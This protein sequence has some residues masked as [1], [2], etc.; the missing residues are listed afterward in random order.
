MDDKLNITDG[1]EL[2]DVGKNDDFIPKDDVNKNEENNSQSDP[3]NP[4]QNQEKNVS[5]NISNFGYIIELFKTWFSKRPL[6]AFR[7]IL[8]LK[9]SLILFAIHLIV[10]SITILLSS[11]SFLSIISK[12]SYGFF[13]LSAMTGKLFIPIFFSVIIYYALLNLTIMIIAKIIKTKN[14]SYVNSMSVVSISLIPI[15]I[16]NL[17]S[18]IIGLISPFLGMMVSL[19]SFIIFPITL[20]LGIQINLGKPQKS[21]YWIFPTAMIVLVLVFILIFYLIASSIMQGMLYD[22]QK[23]NPFGMPQNNLFR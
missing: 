1:N 5:I 15:T 11:S 17:L 8:N 14:S 13:P 4:E 6:N 19:A 10:S 3:I 23:S 16:L 12:L 21:A 22:M 7:R 20:Y 9:E 18:I 2:E